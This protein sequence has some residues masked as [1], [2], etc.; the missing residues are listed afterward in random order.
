MTGSIV[1]G[2]SAVVMAIKD[3]EAVLLTVRPEDAATHARWD[4][5]VLACPDATFFH[6]AGWQKILRRVFR[7][8][9]HYLYAQADGRIEGVAVLPQEGHDDDRRH[10]QLAQRAAQERDHQYPAGF[11]NA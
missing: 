6:R 3:G 8:D 7:H 1:I 5:F 11:R 2:L 4:A 10:Q 9:T